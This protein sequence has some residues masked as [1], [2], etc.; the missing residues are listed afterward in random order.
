MNDL[1]LLEIDFYEKIKYGTSDKDKIALI[2]NGFSNG[3]ANLVVNDYRAFFEID[4]M[5]NTIVINPLLIDKMTENN[6]NDI[7]IYEVKYNTKSNLQE[8]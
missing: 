7:L 6:E 3:L 1:G 5:L 8:I 4:S 2:K